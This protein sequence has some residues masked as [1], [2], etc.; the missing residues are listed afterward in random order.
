MNGMRTKEYIRKVVKEK[1]IP[2]F[3]ICVSKG[4]DTVLRYFCGEGITGKELL[5]MWSM[6]KPLTAACAM[7]LAE[8]GK[9]ALE[10]PVE[11]YL[12]A[13]AE[14]FLTDEKGARI[15][16]QNKMTVRHL[17]TMSGGLDYD[18]NKLPI[19]ALKKR[20]NA[21]TLEFVNAFVRSPL[22]FEP[23]ERFQYGFCHDVLG[24]VIEVASGKRFS[25]YMQ[26]ALFAPLGMENSGFHL[27]KTREV[28]GQY[29]VFSDGKIYRT[30]QENH[31]V[32]G[33]NYDSGGAGVISC[34]DDYAKFAKMLASGGVGEDGKRILKKSTLEQIR[35]AQCAEISVQNSFTCIQGQDYGYGLGMRTRTVAAEWG[36]PVG[37]FGWDGAAASYLMVDPVNR[38]SVVIGMNLL[39]WPPVF[40]GEHLRIVEQ[41]YADMREEGLF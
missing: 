31:L 16:V 19:K 15:P 4:G 7:K 36:L 22:C 1:G 38:I 34:V 40:E 18:G 10:D 6:S 30:E 17:L 23:G 5:Y 33:D 11:K 29:S 26:E 41:V 3:D 27:E 37:E 25:E 12:P 14:A 28:T 32:F 39:N 24:A 20:G 35:S 8:E 9:L 2:Y 21:D 13:Y